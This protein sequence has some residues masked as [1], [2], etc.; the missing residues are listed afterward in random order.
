[1]FSVV[2]NIKI[3]FLGNIMSLF[4]VPLSWVIPKKTGSIMIT[5]GDGY[6]FKDNPKYL[7][8]HLLKNQREKFE[9]YWVTYSKELFNELTAK[10]CPVVKVF[11]LKHI[12]LLLM[13]EFII[14]DD[15]KNPVLFDSLFW[16]YGNFKNILTWHGVGFKKIGLLGDK[17][18][19][20]ND[21]L[22]KL[23]YFLQKEKYRKY[24]AILASSEYDKQ[25]KILCF[26]NKNVFITGMPRNEVL[27]DSSRFR[28]KLKKKYSLENYSKIIVYAPTYREGY[29]IEPFSEAFYKDLNSYCKR[30][31][32][33]F[34][35][36]KHSKDKDFK[37]P[38]NFDHIK[39]LSLEFEDV[40]EL[41]LISDLLISDYSSIST[42]F[43]LIGNPVIFY[44][45]DIEEYKQNSR[46]FSCRLEEML[47]GPFATTEK[48]V[49][50]LT[51]REDWFNN[52]NY[53]DNYERS[54]KLFHQFE[55]GKASERIVNMILKP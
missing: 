27:I 24:S 9:P 22:R 12:R 31:N 28:E 17:Y 39:D 29:F 20:Q 19:K 52:V 8:L 34:L 32:M 54:K 44:I 50:D 38:S 33:I 18:Y 47:P 11:S 6:N 45:H 21:K 16:P 37:L 7:Y 1:M 4:I 14:C 42:D 26:K 25:R 43:L 3:F 53:M 36:K 46:N 10:D 15:T 49:L 35:C 13:A 51:K 48:Q 55:D 40:Q 2:N 5:S 23:K 41:L 30:K